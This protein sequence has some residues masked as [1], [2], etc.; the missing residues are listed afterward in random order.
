ADADVMHPVRHRNLI[1]LLHDAAVREP[2]A[3]EHVVDAHVAH[4]EL[5]LLLP[6]EELLVETDAAGLVGRRKLVPREFHRRGVG[7]FPGRRLARDDEI[8]RAS[9][10]ERVARVWRSAGVTWL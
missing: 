7:L 5:A 6:A 2:I 10:R 9:C 3:A 8:G 1:G 4:V